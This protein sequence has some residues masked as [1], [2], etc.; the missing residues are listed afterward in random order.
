MGYT[1]LFETILDSSIW[2]EDDTTRILWITM[3][4]M[5]NRR[6][7]VLSSLPG[8]AHR[9][10]VTIDAAIKGL[11]KFSG[12]DKFSSSKEYEGR[13]IQPIE[14][15]WLILNGEKYRRRMSQEERREYQRVKQAEY[16]KNRKKS[17]QQRLNPFQPHENFPKDIT[18]AARFCVQA[19]CTP[20]FAAV[21]WQKA[22]SRGGR[23]SKD[24]EIRDFAYYL[25]AQWEYHKAREKIQQSSASPV[26]QQIKAVQEKIDRHPANRGSTFHNPNC[27]QHLKDEL[28]QLKKQLEDLKK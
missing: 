14:G 9:A 23:D 27:G 12:P 16:R 15:G 3:L 18:S 21:T 20:D 2:A 13:R 28:K 24:V 6:H 19:E 25:A 17:E 22:M 4:A 5:R 11:E 10:R 26:W 8:L 1:K 7:E